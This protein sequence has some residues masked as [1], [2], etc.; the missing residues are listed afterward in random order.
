MERTIQACRITTSLTKNKPA[1]QD[2][3]DFLP[4][5]L[6]F[7]AADPQ[8]IISNLPQLKDCEFD[9][10]YILHHLE[11]LEIDRTLCSK[12]S[13]ANKHFA[14][15]EPF[16]QDLYKKSCY[17]ERTPRTSSDMNIPPYAELNKP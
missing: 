3:S 14:S 9:H 6:D 8:P 11:Q 10:N 2:D 7:Q 15:P 17:W 13:I 16:V 4:F 12:F 5:D 1:T